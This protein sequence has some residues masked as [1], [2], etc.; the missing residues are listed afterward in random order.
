MAGARVSGRRPSRGPSTTRTAGSAATIGRP[1][2]VRAT[3]THA[4]RLRRCRHHTRSTARHRTR[5]LAHT[6]RII[7]ANS[8]LPRCAITLPR[9]ASSR[10]RKGIT[11]RSPVLL[12]DV[13]G[14]G[15]RVAEGRTGGREN[16]VILSNIALRSK[17]VL[18][19]T[20]LTTRPV[21]EIGAFAHALL[22]CCV[23]A[24]FVLL[25]RADGLDG[26]N[27]DAGWY[28]IACFHGWV[29]DRVFVIAGE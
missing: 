3:S 1:S 17:A 5:S 28:C 9:G 20:G 7:Q 29:A 6:S 26:L 10:H 15:A 18:K 12:K 19:E 11:C 14:R 24:G 4:V 16:Q 27:G 8:R 25:G 21:R 22:A 2:C 23:V 13:R